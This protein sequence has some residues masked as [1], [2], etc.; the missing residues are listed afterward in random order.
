MRGTDPVSIL[1]GEW[2]GVRNDLQT[3]PPLSDYNRF[4][5]PEGGSTVVS[6]RSMVLV[7]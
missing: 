7:F 2:C 1:S 5:T 4:V 6:I 3:L